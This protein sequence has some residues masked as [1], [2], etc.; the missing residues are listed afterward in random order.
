M[1]T[2]NRSQTSPF[3]VIEVTGSSALVCGYEYQF[4]WAHIWKPYAQLDGP[5][6]RSLPMIGSGVCY[7][8]EMPF[9]FQSAQSEHLG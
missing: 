4:L 8:L 1:C 6:L 9:F 7:L 3:E 5:A 2:E